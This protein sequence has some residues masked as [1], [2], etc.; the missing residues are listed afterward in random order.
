MP[1]K[2]HALIPVGSL[3]ACG[4]ITQPSFDAA[5]DATLDT[6]ADSSNVRDAQ[7]LPCEAGRWGIEVE[8]CCAGKF[9]RGVCTDG[10]ECV[11]GDIPGRM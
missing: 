9:C 4:G 11:C 5:A 10:G 2:L 6:A 7:E 1:V 8:S 3:V